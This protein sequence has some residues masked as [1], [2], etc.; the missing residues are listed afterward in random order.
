[1]KNREILENLDSILS[2]GLPIIKVTD[3]HNILDYFDS[4]SKFEWHTK[5]DDSKLL[6]Y[7][8][9]GEGMFLVTSKKKTCLNFKHHMELYKF[10]RNPETK[11][12]DLP[13]M[14]LNSPKGT[15]I[16][17]SYSEI[18]VSVENQELIES[19]YRSMIK[20][21]KNSLTLRPITPWS[22]DNKL[23][24]RILFDESK[25]KKDTYFWW[26]W[27]E[28]LN[29]DISSIASYKNKNFVFSEDYSAYYESIDKAIEELETETIK[30]FVGLA[31]PSYEEFSFSE[32]SENR[33][34]WLSPAPSPVKKT[35]KELSTKLSDLSSIIDNIL[36]GSKR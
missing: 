29:S 3:F 20:C 36:F 35:R 15:S 30:N 7:W 14:W 18:Q 26:V 10:E 24:N 34:N 16:F 22:Y 5:R 1:M 21:L 33:E 8:Q 12:Y 17:Q 32:C 11:Q 6:K 9:N 31:S 13:E 25:I 19:K 2:L 28:D 23:W 27:S 4:I